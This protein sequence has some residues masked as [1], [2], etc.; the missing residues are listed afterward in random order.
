MEEAYKG[1]VSRIESIEICSLP[2]FVQLEKEL[3][4]QG[5]I[6]EEGLPFL[7]VSP[8]MRIAAQIFLDDSRGHDVSEELIEIIQTAGSAELLKAISIV[9][10]AGRQSSTGIPFPILSDVND[11]WCGDFDRMAQSRSSSLMFPCIQSRTIWS[12]AGLT[13]SASIGFA[14]LP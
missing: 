10:S 9:C 6:A 11:S 3:I 12:F 8:K 1:Y 13:C 2:E 14:V 5:I 7:N 4:S